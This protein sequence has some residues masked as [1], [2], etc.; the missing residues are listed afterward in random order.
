MLQLF[1]LLGA[2]LIGYSVRH[3]SIKTQILNQ[4]LFVIVVLILFVMGYEFGS[5]TTDLWGQ[6]L[7]I[8]KKVLVFG[9]LLFIFNLITTGVILSK[10]NNL[11]RVENQVLKKANYWQFTLESGKY[12]VIIA[13]GVLAG[14]LLKKPL[15]TITQIINILLFILLFIIGHQM[16]VGGVALKDAIFNKTG[17]KL[18]IA[19]I[20]SSLIAGVLAAFI[21]GL[22][23]GHGLMLSSG[24]GWYTLSSILDSGLINQSFGTTAFFIDFSRELLAIIFLPSLGRYFPV[25]MVGYCGGTAMDFS[26]PIIKQNLHQNCVILAISSG[27]ILSLAVPVLIPLFARL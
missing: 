26:L 5:S 21:L 23:I 13:S 20:V 14:I 24:F 2:L 11:M 25:S 7:Q 4:V 22:P 8:G 18:A 9:G 17:L 19:I 16:R 12:I 10:E 27:M 3:L 6:L 1:T 15:T